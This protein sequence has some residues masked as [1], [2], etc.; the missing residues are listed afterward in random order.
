VLPGGELGE[1][2]VDPGIVTRD[3]ASAARVT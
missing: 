1:A 2:P 3:P